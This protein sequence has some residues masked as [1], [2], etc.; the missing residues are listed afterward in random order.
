MIE[1]SGI[2]AGDEGFQVTVN[3]NTDLK[4]AVIASSAQA[5]ADGKNSLTTGTLTTSDL[6]N[7]AEFNASSVGI[8]GGYSQ[9]SSMIPIGG[10]TNTAAGGVGTDQQGN[11]QTG[12]SQTPGSTLPS[13]NGFSAT[14]PVAMNASGD[15]SSTTRSGVS[16][17][18]LTITEEA[19]Q[20]TLTG[21]DAATTVASLNRD[22]STGKDASN[23]LAPVFNEQEIQAGFA[24]VGALSREVGTFLDN[25][26]K[27]ADAKIKL[28]KEAELKVGDASNGLSDEQR[29][30]LRD[31]AILLRAD[32]QSINN[33]WGA[34][35]TYRQLT[36]A[37]VAAA[38]GNVSATSQEFVQNM[39]VNYV[40]QQGATY[41]GKLVADGTLT[42]GSPLHASLHAIIA[43]GGAA[44]SGQDCGSGALGAAGSSLLTG[45]FSE[46]SPDETQSERQA[47]ANLIASIVTG[48]AVSSGQDAATATNAAVVAIDNN[49]LATQQIVQ[50]N[51]ELKAAQGSLETLKVLGKWAYVN[52]KQ[53]ALT[54][55][56][57]GKGLAE[58]GWSDVQGLAAFLSDPITGLKGLKEIITNPDARQQMGDAMFAE[59]DAKIDRMTTALEV[60]GYQQAEQLGEDLGALIW[61]VG[62][63]A[64]G[65]GGV[66]KGGVA[67]AKVG[68][69]VGTKGLE[70]L[71]GL[72]KFESLVAKG[73]LFGLDGK[74]LMDFRVLTNA[75]KSVIGDVMGGEK[76]IEMIPGAQKVGRSPGIG[77]TGIDDLYKVDK[78]GVDYVVVEYK[79][80]SSVLKETKDGLQMSD[81]WLTGTNTNY[82]R[83][84][85][86]VGRSEAPLVREALDSGRV[87]K[88]LVHTDPFGNVTVGVLDKAGKFIPNPQQASKILGSAK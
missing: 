35:G 33:N 32:A 47:K 45:L 62:A 53:D 88:W 80:G 5:V 76:I 39:L 64:T 4:G 27:E 8:G 14:P 23:A 68:V 13:L 24:I 1:Q 44:A 74:P 26:A 11:A 81:S 87:E 40:Q 55:T 19:K 67:L 38:S 9:G 66:A 43:C 50:M 84:L 58:A 86:S 22:V 69:S 36:T 71:S 41:I 56:G 42:E 34:G 60:G 17:A 59:L 83:I 73:G 63:V 51:K 12:A 18:T 85:E 54:I 2:K 15:A 70:T 7:K 28:A 82:N 37:L 31:Q 77:Q 52:G 6:H 16:G 20:Q 10:G 25:R 30:A 61:Q 72:A 75:Q 46:T 78:P 48:L 29:Q 79:F 3:G 57:V 21:Q 65:V 49:W